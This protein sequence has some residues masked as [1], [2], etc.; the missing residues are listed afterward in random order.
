MSRHQA[1]Q[2]WPLFSDSEQELIIAATFKHLRSNRDDAIDY[3]ESQVAKRLKWQV[4]TVRTTAPEVLAKR[5]RPL[6]LVALPESLWPLAMFMARALVDS[7]VAVRFMNLLGVK[8]SEIGTPDVGA[9]GKVSKAKYE[10]AFQALMSEF[11]SGRVSRLLGAL[12]AQ[13]LTEAPW[14]FELA[15]RALE[16][17]KFEENWQRRYEARAN[18]DAEAG[19]DA[20]SDDFTVLDR[21]LIDSV[22]ATVQG[23]DG[24][25]ESEDLAD[26]VSN[27]V[28]LNPKRKK[29]L[30][31]AGFMDGVVP[32]RAL[33]FDQPE[34]NA[35]RREWYLAGVT[36]ALAR[37]G[38]SERLRDVLKAR[39]EDFRRAA[40]GKSGAGA[41][42]AKTSFDF[43][44]EKNHVA[45]ATLL[46]K[47]QLP[48]AGER[49]ARRA[50]R[51]AVTKVL[52][53]DEAAAEPLLG[54][55]LRWLEVEPDI[56]LKWIRKSDILRRYAQCLQARGDFDEA[57]RRFASML[58]SAEDPSIPVDMALVRGRF[59]RLWD[60][61]LPQEDEARNSLAE[62]LDR[63][64]DLVD[65]A[66]EKHGDKA[67]N[68]KFVKG[69]RHY[70]T[71]TMAKPGW[72]REQP[73]IKAIELLSSAHVGMRNSELAPA[74]ESTGVLELLLFMLA[75]LRMATLDAAD[76]RHAL[77]AWKQ[78]TTHVHVFPLQDVRLLVE[79]A[80][81]V[82][83]G[84]AA[85]IAESVWR[86]RGTSAAPM[87]GELG[88]LERSASLQDSHVRAA[89]DE[90]LPPTQRFGIAK[91]AC[92][93]ASKAGNT[94]IAEAAFDA[95]DQLS[96]N[97]DVAELMHAWLVGPAASIP[98]ISEADRLWLQVSVLR[99]LG[100]DEDAI[101]QLRTL[102]FRARDGAKWQREQLAEYMESRHIPLSA[103]GDPA[104]AEILG[105]S[106]V[107]I[108]KQGRGS[109][110][111]VR[112]L[113]VGGNEIQEQ[114]DE[115]IHKILA[116]EHNGISVKFVH[117]GWTSNWGEQAKGILNDAASMDAVV[118]MVFMR[119]MLGR[120]IRSGLGDVPWV[121]CSAHGRDGVLRS[122]LKAAEV[123]R[124]LDASAR[125]VT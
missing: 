43:M 93:A 97:G 105:H 107:A 119:T 100:R 68:A 23:A 54:E 4:R 94:E 34:L 82:D 3:V 29:S 27:V 83:V 46:L 32:G 108:V 124:S 50:L 87:L 122:I 48:A 59:R 26:L 111:P 113:F 106:S 45:E 81:L 90:Q 36:A 102:Y 72:A 89:R 98:F 70:L 21:V 12:E 42:I 60:I 38:D 13:H 103:F 114:Y 16:L 101:G 85:E 116:E 24:A 5:I 19:F 8:A 55:L 49:L 58:E 117:T 104:A 41:S 120:A 6:A 118:L 64:M 112:I 88:L 11:D 78:I 109:V 31:H 84:V 10:S 71:F 37:K 66:I 125:K 123:A 52:S 1:Q 17:I 99:R 33:N 79:N 77:A 91:I 63:G 7:D 40:A 92:E 25:L 86:Y 75:V 76:A 69:L 14:L 28:A 30:F 9:L 67:I 18:L 80:S 51:H 110:R 62:S 65:G 2:L 95:M 73:R 39:N 61:A 53:N 47:G 35:D 57:E 44:C 121:S 74:Y 115:V 20:S 22:V 15:A 96:S 56:E